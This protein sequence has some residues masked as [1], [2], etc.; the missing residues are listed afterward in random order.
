MFTRRDDDDTLAPQKAPVNETDEAI[1]QHPVVF[2]ELRDVFA[3]R[4]LAPENWGL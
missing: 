1:E 4:D 2:V 3:W